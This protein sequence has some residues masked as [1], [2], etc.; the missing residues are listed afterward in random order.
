[1]PDVRYVCLSDLH[2]GAENSVLTCM[3]PNGLDVDPRQPSTVMTALVA[4]LAELVSKNE[5][6]R[7][8]TLILCGDI[9]ELALATDNVAAMVF[10]RFVE[11]A[12][13]PNG[14]LFGDTIY[15]V[16]GNHDHHLWEGA[17][18]RQYADY[19][20]RHPPASDLNV[21]WHTTR[22]FTELDPHPAQ[23]EV[24]TM[25]MRRYPHLKDVTVRAVYPN[26]GLL[27]EDRSR[28]LIVHHGH[29]VENMY[30]LMSTLRDIVFPGRLPPTRVYEWEAENFA[31]IDFFW[32]T[33]GRSGQVGVDVGFLYASLQSEKAMR[34][35]ARNVGAGIAARL[36]GPRPLRWAEGK[37]IELALARLAKRMTH[38]ERSQ[39]GSPLSDRGRAG[40]GLYL[41][42]PV[43]NQLR[44][45]LGRA[46]EAMPARL[47]F[48]FGHTHKPFELSLRPAGYPGALSLYNTGGWV[49]DTTHTAPLQGG[50]AILVDEDLNAVAVRVYNQAD[51]ASSY[52]VR[53][54]EVD[55]AGA[56]PL[57]DRI[58]AIIDPDKPPWSTVSAA[59]ADLVAQ[60]HVDLAKLIERGATVVEPP[61]PGPSY[62]GGPKP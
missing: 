57:F 12:F 3:Q 29:Y 25:L 24:L 15:F 19:L 16:P 46:P 37:A 35:V 42:G 55:G 34:Q 13:P 26:L 48:V 10:E 6:R 61:P 32:S 58:D 8:P 50:S 36:G 53:V 62:I 21:P 14:A 28:A 43:L 56:N 23:A 17:R 39:P 49:V 60:R 7:K 59:A 31:W 51:S 27:S 20:R 54:A 33:L 41:E 22:M 9:L 47:T 2:F 52:R 45:E 11:L 4:C 38:L 5:G 30:R 44:D 40:L 18:E 1:M